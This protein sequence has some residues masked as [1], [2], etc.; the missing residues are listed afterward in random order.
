[1]TIEA[2]TDY[3]AFIVGLGPAGASAA[4]AL[5]K[6]GYRVLAIDRK[7]AP[8]TPVQCAEFVPMM[9]ANETNIAVATTVQPIGDMFTFVESDA[10]DQACNFSGRMIDRHAF[11][12]GLVAEAEAAG[13]DCHFASP[14]GTLSRDGVITC[15]GRPFRAKIIIGADGPHS[16]IGAAIGS[17]NKDVLETRQIT[18]PLLRPHQGTD[19]FLSADYPGGYGWLFPKGDKANI[20][21]GLDHDQRDR[22]KPLL[23]ELHQRLMDETRV[24]A[25]ISYHTGGAIPA[26]GLL[27]P[28]GRLGESLVLLAGDAAGLT[29][30]ITGAG[31]AAAIMSGKLAGEAAIAFLEGDQQAGQD[32]AEDLQDM[33]GAALTRACQHRQKLKTIRQ[34][35][36]APSPAHLRNSWIAYPQYWH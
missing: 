8:G 14:L 10:P 23:E 19:I 15:A 16:S 20:G 9:M 35:E 34:N 12:A 28:Q 17:I 5:A 26:G 3:D 29:N 24:G 2:T 13:A 7:P 32:Y 6:A 11:D 27:D 25:E 4:T 18:V 36:Q 1:M 33:F 22:L 21:L 31:I 30:C